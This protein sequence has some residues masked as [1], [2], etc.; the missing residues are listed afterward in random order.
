MSGIRRAIGGGLASVGLRHPATR[1]L[2][3]AAGTALAIHFSAAT[4]GSGNFAIARD[5]TARPWIITSNEPN[6]TPVPW[7]LAAGA[8]GTAGLVFL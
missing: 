2:V 7:W 4:S 6:A 5:G 1:F 3:G 8:A